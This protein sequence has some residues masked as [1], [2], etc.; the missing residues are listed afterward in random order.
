MKRQISLIILLAAIILC[1]C[2]DKLPGEGIGTLT[3]GEQAECRLGLNVGDFQVISG[4]RASDEEK[5]ASDAEKKI[6]NIWVFQYDADGNLIINPKYYE[7]TNSKNTDGSWNVV[8][9][10]KQSTIYVVANTNDSI[11][12]SD[13]SSFATLAA[14]KTKSL[15]SPYPI[16]VGSGDGFV[17][18][19]EVTI[20]MAGSLDL[21][22]TDFASDIK[23]DV[24]RMYAKLIIQTKMLNDINMT[25]MEV[26]N[27]PYNCQIEPRSTNNDP[28]QKTAATYSSVEFITR[29]YNTTNDATTTSG[30]SKETGTYVIYVPE[31]IQ[32]VNKY[33]SEED[34]GQIIKGKDYGFDD[35]ECPSNALAVKYSLSIKKDNSDSRVQGSATVFPGANNT[36]NFNVNRNYVYKINAN[37]SDKSFFFPTPSSNCFVVAPGDTIT[38][39]P[40]YRTEKGGGYDIKNYLD[41]TDPA[42]TIKGLK[43]IWQDKDVIGD[44]TNGDLVTISSSASNYTKYDD[45]IKEF[46]IDVKTNKE[47]NALIGAYNNA[48]CTGDVLW[49][50][51]IW[52]T[53]NEPDNV[54]NAIR[55][56][57]YEWDKDGIYVNKARVP[58]YQVMPCNLGAKALINTNTDRKAFGLLYQW[59]RKDPFPPMSKGGGKTH[60]TNDNA[61]I[62]YGNA[63]T[64]EVVYKTSYDNDNYLFHTHLG[65]ELTDAIGY[66]VAH[67]TVFIAGTNNLNLS[68]SEGGSGTTGNYDYYF[69]GGDWCPNGQSDNKL[70]GGLDPDDNTMNH[71]TVNGVEIYDNYGSSKTIYDPCPTGWRVP[72]G[73]LWLGFTSTGMNP[74]SLNE[75]NCKYINDKQ[76]YNAGMYMYLEG[77]KTG[78]PSYFPTPGARVGDG[79]G[80][81]NGSCGNYHNASTGKDNKLNILHLHADNYNLFNI[82]ENQYVMYHVKSCAGPIRCVRDK[83]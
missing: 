55:Y 20:P 2:S 69:N 51:H 21:A 35:S 13:A 53:D 36:N 1:G 16:Q 49:S 39:W 63:N 10:V 54:G 6:D 70:W 82:F 31:N 19:N 64:N 27:I 60:Y 61:G 66:S 25:G 23:V 46:T 29:S 81:R 38:F 59:G 8:L 12:A 75:I 79:M 37:F 32:G 65:K 28:Y 80:I 33:L 68:T 52:V 56:T 57:T 34:K 41:P 43:I 48:E 40:Y 77:W 3:E 15:P 72:P 58:G 73:D 71:L 45:I 78:T 17:A 74:K 24:V 26:N 76:N 7:S 9:Y 62:H 42:K 67:P 4:T 14:L 50:W 22:T 11:W 18:A 44:N 5:K 47:G 83:K 30:S